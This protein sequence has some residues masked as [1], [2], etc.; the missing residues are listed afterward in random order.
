[1]VSKTPGVTNSDLDAY[2]KD[3][4][5]FDPDFRMMKARAC[6][7]V[8]KDSAGLLDVVY[9]DKIAMAF[10]KH[11]SDQNK[12]VKSNA[13]YCID[14][15]QGKIRPVAYQK[16][17]DSMCERLANESEENITIFTLAIR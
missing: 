10:V 1:M 5:H 9:E 6:M 2:L 12:E 7:K 14:Q 4:S 13:V 3:C 8:I 16:I 11:L 15:I 17:L